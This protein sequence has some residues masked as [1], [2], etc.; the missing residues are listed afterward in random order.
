MATGRSMQLTKQVGEYLV[1][2]EL[3]R[4]GLIS[5]T[6]TGNVPGF[7]ILAT[8]ER[9]LTIPIQV[10]TMS[11]DKK[12]WQFKDIKRDFLDISISNNIQEVKGKKRLK[13]RDL[14]Y[15]FIKLKEQNQDEYYI[16][17]MRDLQDIIYRKY[18]GWLAKVRGKR[19]RNPNSTHCS[20]YPKDV[21]DYKNRWEIITN[22]QWQESHK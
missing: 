17:R 8:N 4:R 3:C 15:V 19:P 11:K 18:K 7:D 16:I 21:K 14:I 10:K 9:L 5:T 2:A 13:A 1:A 22:S 12:T 20:L 6:F